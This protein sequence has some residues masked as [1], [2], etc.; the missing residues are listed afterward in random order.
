MGEFVGIGRLSGRI[1]IFFAAMVRHNT[2]RLNRGHVRP[3]L[4][5]ATDSLQT[6]SS[7]IP[8]LPFC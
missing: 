3:E 5:Q 7:A 1:D 4:L 8:F 6:L 2:V